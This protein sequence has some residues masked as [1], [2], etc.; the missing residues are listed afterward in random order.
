MTA[1]ERRPTT[2]V[3][4]FRAEETRA[5]ARLEEWDALRDEQAI[6][7]WVDVETPDDETLARLGEQFRLDPR[8]L[9]LARRREREPCVRF[10]P[11]QFLVTVLSV[12]VEEQA[13]RPRA[14]V[15]EMDVLVGRNFVITLRDGP[16]PFAGQLQ[17]RTAANP[18][19]GRFDAAYLLYVL[20]DSLVDHYAQEIGEIEDEVARLEE[21][22]V[23]EHGRRAFDR[24]LILKRHVER[25]RRLIAPHREAFGALVGADSPIE[26]E[27]G[28]AYFRDLTMRIG[29]VV[30]RLNQLRDQVVSSFNLYTSNLSHRNNQQLRVLTFLSAILLPL[31]A[32]TGLF[33][34]NFKL[35]A[36]EAWEPF[37][38]ML[39][40][41]GAITVGMLAFFRRK[42][43]L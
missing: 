21:R 19:L 37:Y 30:D 4:V 24:A 23:R 5:D 2:N 40:G 38:V 32:I 35:T 11:D 20:L 31:T 25:V 15:V 18:L 6:T 13:E 17:E 22:L 43:W 3:Y 33:G 29:G 41:M 9:A 34:T 26:A 1:T 12:D 36:Y 27:N 16:L 14:R 10:Y 28:E 42:G 8:A 39:A 7:F